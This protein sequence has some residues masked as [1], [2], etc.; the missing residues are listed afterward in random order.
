MVKVYSIGA[1][2]SDTIPTVVS[3]SVSLANNT[4]DALQTVAGVDYAVTAGKSLYIGK[5]IIRITEAAQG[6]LR[7]GYADDALGTGF[8]ALLPAKLL[9]SGTN[10]LEEY[11]IPLTAVPAGKYLVVHN[12]AY[13][14]AIE[15]KGI[16]VV[17]VEE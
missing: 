11:E 13:G 7:F 4:Y 5:W 12:N 16:T 1:L 8:V 3:L 15:I 17:G 6:F 14:A 9:F 10:V 2:K